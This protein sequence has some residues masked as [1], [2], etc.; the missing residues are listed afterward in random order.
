[1]HEYAVTKSMIALA[2]EEA[3]KAG[4]KKIIEIRLVIGDLSTI[5]DESV[6]MYFDIISEGTIAFGAKLVFR[7]VPAEF[8]C[9]DCGSIFD[10][11]AKGFDC[12]GC[13][14]LGVPTGVGK[15]FYIESI[16]V[17]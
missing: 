15:E 6:Q 13:S 4:A 3:E 17:E 1:M 12:P 16:E 7:R 10:K 5:I 8:R 9:K 14:G 2:V 11:P